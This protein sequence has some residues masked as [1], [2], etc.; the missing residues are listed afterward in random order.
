MRTS[1][2]NPFAGDAYQDVV[3]TTPIRFADDLWELDGET[4][5]RRTNGTI[6]TFD[7]ELLFTG[8]QL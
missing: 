7:A 6:E 5:F 3:G 4:A 1:F 8:G 2:I